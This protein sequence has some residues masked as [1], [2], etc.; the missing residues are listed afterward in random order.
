M[1]PH[2]RVE[3]LSNTITVNY[4]NNYDIVKDKLHSF[5]T[6]DTTTSNST[7]Q[8]QSIIGF[9]T[10]QLLLLE[11]IGQQ[12]A[13]IISTHSSTAPTG[14]TITLSGNLSQS[15]SKDTKVSIVQFDAVD[16][17]W[18]LTTTGGKSELSTLAIDIRMPETQYSDLTQSSGYYFARFYDTTQGTAQSSAF[19]DPIPYS[20]YSDNTVYEIK[21][22]AL[23]NVGEE[24]GNKIT[25][26]FLN[27]CLWQARREYHDSPGKRPF[28]RKYGVDIGNVSTGI[29]RTLS[30]SD[31]ERPQTAE[32]LYGVRIGVENNLD[33]YDKKDFDQDY[34]DIPHSTLV[35]DYTVGNTHLSLTS[36]R[37]FENSGAISIAEDTIEYSAKDITTG[38]LTISTQGTSNHTT[39]DDTWQNVS[40]GL[41]TKF[42]VFIDSS[43]SSYIYFNRPIE[44]LYVDQNIY[45]DYYRTL[46]AYDS[47]ADELD[48]PEYDMF[49]HYLSF[50]IKKKLN[51]ELKA[52]NDD[53][54]GLWIQKKN[55]ALAK[56]YLGTEIRFVPDVEN[57]E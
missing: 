32:N 49:V 57:L 15:H 37:D 31:L 11:E 45:A 47:D 40:Y 7:L 5:L 29:Y 33:Y 13:E 54:Y 6:A 50:R 44:T 38:S 25:H 26:A 4:V 43:G 10:N 16:F 9:K 36:A 42:V 35:E 23:D 12:D 22:R 34:R 21:R 56:E 55:T 20:G 41:P 52:Q 1:K 51:P 46:V 39:G 53:D 17:E 30:P 28:R 3:N 27:G 24:I 14:T 19:S 48:E 8:V 2:L 18:A